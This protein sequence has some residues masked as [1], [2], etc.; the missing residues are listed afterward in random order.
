MNLKKDTVRLLCILLSVVL[1]PFLLITA[2]MN[3]KEKVVIKPHIFYNDSFYNRDEAL[4]EASLKELD[5]TLIQDGTIDTLLDITEVCYD[6]YQTNL[7]DYLN[8][9]IYRLKNE[10]ESMIYLQISPLSDTLL[11]FRQEK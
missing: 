1:I 4:E 2:V 11:L 10:D 3:S 6:N 8:A 9:E 7:E 5:G